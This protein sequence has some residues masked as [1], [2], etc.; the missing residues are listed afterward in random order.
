MTRRLEIAPLT[1][2][3]RST[4]SSYYTYG[5]RPENVYYHEP[6]VQAATG[7]PLS[8]FVQGGGTGRSDSIDAKLSDG[9]Y[10]LDAT[11]VSLLGDGSS[12][13]G[14]AKLDRMRKN[15]WKQKGKGMVKGN[16]GVDAK[17]PD[18]YLS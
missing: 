6:A 16:F 8:R 9:E 10:V 17:D 4:P 18:E 2:T 11:T 3:R 15:I 13:A 5:S 7:G 1:R 14:A 12:K